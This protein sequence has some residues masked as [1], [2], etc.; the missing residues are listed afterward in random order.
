VHIHNCI[1]EHGRHLLQ[2][3]T[4]G[5]QDKRLV[6]IVSRQERNGRLTSGK[7]KITTTAMTAVSTMNTT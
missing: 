1:P 2:S 7:K 3:E 6:S 5:L 4:F